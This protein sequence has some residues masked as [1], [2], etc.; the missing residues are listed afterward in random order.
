MENLAESA[1]LAGPGGLPL[2]LQGLARLRVDSQRAELAADD[3]RN[4][5][6]GPVY[7]LPKRNQ[8]LKEQA[9]DNKPDDVSS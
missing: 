8:C 6:A 2:V 9:K 4:G 1:E 5:G 3:N 7:R